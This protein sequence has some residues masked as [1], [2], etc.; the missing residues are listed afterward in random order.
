MTTRAYLPVV[1]DAPILSHCWLFVVLVNSFSLA[2]DEGFH[3]PRA[4]GC[5]S[6]CGW[7]CY[8][9][10][11]GKSSINPSITLQFCFNTQM[12]TLDTSFNIVVSSLNTGVGS[13]FCV[14]RARLEQLL[15]YGKPWTFHGHSTLSNPLWDIMGWSLRHE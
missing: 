2:A 8:S 4:G 3:S 9:K 11:R 1:L 7:S 6:A 14:D 13:T 10:I 12:F 5:S 15:A